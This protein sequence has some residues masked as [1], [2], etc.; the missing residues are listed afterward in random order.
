M[1]TNPFSNKNGARLPRFKKIFVHTAFVSFSP[2]H[3]ATPYPFW[4]RFYKISAHAQL[5]S[6]H[7]HFNISAREIGALLD[8]LL[9]SVRHIGYSR[10]SGLAPGRV[11]FL[12]S[13]FRSCL[14]SPLSD[15]IVF[16]AHTWKQRFQNASFLNCSTLESVFEWL[17]FRWSFLALQC[18][19]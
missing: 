19:R 12:F 2:V 14:F 8:S 18:R 13:I 1:H 6:T 3:T 11:Y 17:R 10:S 7:A 4:K 15:G 5:N 9:A 16:S